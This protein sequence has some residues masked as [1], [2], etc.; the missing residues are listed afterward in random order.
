MYEYELTDVG[1][2]ITA[3]PEGQAVTLTNVGQV[4][5]LPGGW[6]RVKLEPDAEGTEGWVVFPREA[7]ITVVGKDLWDASRQLLDDLRSRN[8]DAFRGIFGMGNS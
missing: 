5:I 4:F 8:Q 3:T 2:I 7:I 6:L 1:A